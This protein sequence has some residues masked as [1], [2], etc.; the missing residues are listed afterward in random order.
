MLIHISRLNGFVFL[1]VTD[2]DHGHGHDF[3]VE[4]TSEELK[5]EG[6]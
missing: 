4:R 3:N 6:G 5:G 1:F 2:T